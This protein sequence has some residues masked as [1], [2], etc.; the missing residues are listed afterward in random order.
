MAKS[1]ILHFSLDVTVPLGVGESEVENAINAVLNEPPCDW[2]TW[3]VGAAV[4]TS[5]DFAEDE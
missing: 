2:E 1:R 5:A 4:I 3:T